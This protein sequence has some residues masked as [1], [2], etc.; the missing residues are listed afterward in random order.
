VSQVLDPAALARLAE[1]DPK[2]ENHLLERVLQAFQTSVARLRPQAE[3]ARQKGDRAGVRLV[4]HTLKSSS[5]SIG[6]MHLS[7]LCAQI[8]TTIRVES[9]ED[10]EALL[11]AFNAALDDVLRATARLLEERA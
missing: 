5:A 1:L 9:G 7:Q 3:A 6:A 8:E 4:V 10:L 2:G 11:D